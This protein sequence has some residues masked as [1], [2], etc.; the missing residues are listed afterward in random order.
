VLLIEPPY[1]ERQFLQYEEMPRQFAA[2]MEQY[3]NVTMAREGWK[4]KL[5]ENRFFSDP[6]HLNQEGAR[7]YTGE[8]YQEFKEAFLL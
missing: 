7:R 6:T 5:Y 8:I 3:S 1:R 4:L 2:L